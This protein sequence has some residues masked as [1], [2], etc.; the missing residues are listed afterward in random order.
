MPTMTRLH[1]ADWL[2]GQTRQLGI[3]RPTGWE[4]V[5]RF[6]EPDAEASG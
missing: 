3:R 5:L 4:V 1:A 6:C 2:S